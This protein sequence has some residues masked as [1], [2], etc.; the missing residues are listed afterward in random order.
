M[1]ILLYPLAFVPIKRYTEGVYS[2]DFDTPI[3]IGG[4]LYSGLV[5]LETPLLF[6]VLIGINLK[7]FLIVRTRKKAN[8]GVRD[9]NLRL[10]ETN[11]LMRAT[12]LQVS[13]K[14]ANFFAELTF[15]LG[16]LKL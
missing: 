6:A 1:L 15:L 9:T 4:M 13:G 3:S 5:L 2:C 10:K 14:F 11:N 7:I 12:V 16:S 8:I